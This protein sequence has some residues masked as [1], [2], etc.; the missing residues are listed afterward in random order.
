MEGSWYI[1]TL[2][3]FNEELVIKINPNSKIRNLDKNNKIDA[4]VISK[5]NG[6]FIDITFLYQ[7]LDDNFK[8]KI[9]Y[10]SNYSDGQIKKTVSNKNLI[11]IIGKYN[12]IDIKLGIKNTVDWFID[13]YDNCRK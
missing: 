9:L 3:P 5:K 11:D 13:N 7:S 10:D 2:N 4:R 12:F 8:N 6:V 1:L